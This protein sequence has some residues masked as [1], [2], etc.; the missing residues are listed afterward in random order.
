MGAPIPAVATVL[1]RFGGIVYTPDGRRVWVAAAVFVLTGLELMLKR[2]GA[3]LTGRILELTRIL[4]AA[5]GG[6]GRGRG[7]EM[8]L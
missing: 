5:A 6:S 3:S 7:V 1:V 8:V 2:P 4:A